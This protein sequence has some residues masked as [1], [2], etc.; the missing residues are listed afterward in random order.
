[1]TKDISSRVT[2]SSASEARGCAFLLIS[3]LNPGFLAESSPAADRETEKD[4]KERG[5]KERERIV[6]KGI[7]EF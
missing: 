4:R 3:V 5:E 6:W 7:V 2:L 1:M